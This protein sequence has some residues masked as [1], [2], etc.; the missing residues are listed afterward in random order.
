MYRRVVFRHSRMKNIIKRGF[1]LSVSLV[2]IVVL[3]PLLF[4]I[5]VWVRF[6]SSGRALF[7]Q[8]R[9]GRGQR[10]FRI[11]KFRT[12]VDRDPDKIDQHAEQVVGDGEDSRITRAGKIL[13][14]TSLDELPQ[15]FN[16]LRGDM[17][18]VGPRPVLPE[19]L[20]AVP[21]DCF[22]RFDVRPGLTGLAQIRGRRSLDWL[23]QLEADSE[24]A[25]SFGFWSDIGILLRTVRVVLKSEGVY[26]GERQNWRTYRDRLRSQQREGG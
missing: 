1:D 6:D 18:L 7:V 17:S 20:E 10:V 8:R 14:K 5:A 13:R 11:L 3:A 16:V 15:L 2:A 22:V 23:E 12:M 24:Y 25:R 26:A 19:Q 4:A 9:V 21:P